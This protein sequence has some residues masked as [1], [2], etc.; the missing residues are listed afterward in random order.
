VNIG[1]LF[2]L[3]VIVSVFISYTPILIRGKL[4]Y[5]LLTV[6][7][8]IISN[9]ASCNISATL[10]LI[11]ILTNGFLISATAFI[12]SLRT[13][14][15]TLLPSLLAAFIASLD[16]N[17][18]TP[19]LRFKNQPLPYL[20]IEN[21]VT[22]QVLLNVKPKNQN[23]PQLPIEENKKHYSENDFSDVFDDLTS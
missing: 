4:L 9:L 13:L 22:K 14:A 6:L 16:L 18:N 11:S 2:I 8:F 23:L 10:L 15:A 21:P 17:V 19:D 1:L 7:L 20:P 5:I 12:L 3:A